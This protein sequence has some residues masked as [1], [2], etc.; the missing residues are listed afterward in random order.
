MGEE[1]G[2]GVFILT[3]NTSL[4][5][6]MYRFQKDAIAKLLQVCCSDFAFVNSVSH[7]NADS[8]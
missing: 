6:G 7:N 2:V 3:D 5:L 4:L 8:L 1:V